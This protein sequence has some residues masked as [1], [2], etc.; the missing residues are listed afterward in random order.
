MGSCFSSITT[1]NWVQPPT[2]S[3]VCLDGSLREY[4]TAVKVYEVLGSLHP[5]CFL[6]S[7]DELY[8]DADIPALGS[9]Q[10]LELGQLYFMLPVAKLEHRLTGSEMAALAVKASL[11]LAVAVETRRRTI[12]VM[13]VEAVSGVSE[14]EEEIF[15]L[16]KFDEFSYGISES[17]RKTGMSASLRVKLVGRRFNRLRLST[18][19]ELG[20]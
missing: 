1:T 17:K 4:L 8:I 19:G 15:S 6:C 3:V 2:A 16:K 18:I 14:E 12:Q 5:S 20:E 11:A 13:P 9:N 7:S 10:S